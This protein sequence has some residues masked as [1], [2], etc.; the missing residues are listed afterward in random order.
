MKQLTKDSKDVKTK[1]HKSLDPN[2]WMLR[3]IIIFALLELVLM[4]VGL[5]IFA[6]VQGYAI[7]AIQQ[8]WFSS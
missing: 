7:Q 5:V 2:T 3:F 6:T 4:I 8:W 1:Q